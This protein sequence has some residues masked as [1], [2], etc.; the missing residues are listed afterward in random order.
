MIRWTQEEVRYIL[1]N[2]LLKTNKEMAEC[3]NKT[4]LS[5]DAKM[6]RMR[7]LRSES[8]RLNHCIIGR[9][10]SKGQKLEN[11]GNW[12]GG[13]SKNHYHYKKIQMGRYPERVRARQEVFNAIQRGEIIRQPCSVCGL[14][15]AHAHHE[16]YSK[17]LDVMW[18]CRKHHREIH[19]GKH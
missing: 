6:C 4:I 5:V 18:L 15:K 19:D 16:D 8:V 3:L 10:K 9:K 17:P 14:E 2:Y 11:N 7:L 1:D 12:K 13:I